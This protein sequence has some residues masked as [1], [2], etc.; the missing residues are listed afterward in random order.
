M[1]A[2]Y[3]LFFIILLLRNYNNRLMLFYYLPKIIIQ[4]LP[5]M[6]TIS[7][8]CVHLDQLQDHLLDLFEQ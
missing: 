3:K 4:E 2:E 8:H 6:N 1:K 7:I 5:H